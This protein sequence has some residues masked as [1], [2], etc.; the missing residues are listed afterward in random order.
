MRK[1]FCEVGRIFGRVGPSVR[2]WIQA[3]KLCVWARL[4][5]NPGGLA[6]ENAAFHNHIWRKLSAY[7]E[8]RKAMIEAHAAGILLNRPVS[9]RFGEL[10]NKLQDLID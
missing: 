9:V 5:E 2:V 1:I 10:F 3:D 6:H 8:G 4:L 7:A